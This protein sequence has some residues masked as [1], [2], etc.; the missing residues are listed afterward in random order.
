MANRQTMFH[1][2]KGSPS[3]DQHR[4]RILCFG[5][6]EWGRPI[7]SSSL[8]EGHWITEKSRLFGAFLRFWG[9]SRM[10]MTLRLR[11][12]AKAIFEDLER[13]RAV[14]GMLIFTCLIEKLG[15]SKLQIPVAHSGSISSST[16]QR[17]LWMVPPY[18]PK[19]DPWLLLTRSAL[20]PPWLPTAPKSDAA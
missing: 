2:R 20:V 16:I 19:R 4:T 15:L 5:I 6:L 1:P 18:K 7:M 12:V 8:L 13:E 17:L 3:L 11:K 9:I 10:E 14:A